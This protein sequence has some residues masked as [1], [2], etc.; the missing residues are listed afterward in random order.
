MTTC[1]YRLS[2]RTRPF[3]F[4]REKS[5]EDMLYMA[6]EMLV[7]RGMAQYGDTIIFVAGV[8]AGVARTTNVMKLHK[9]GEEVK[10]H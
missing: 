3:L 9:I 6:S 4:R 2:S 10:L 8:P 7:V 1:Q 5:L